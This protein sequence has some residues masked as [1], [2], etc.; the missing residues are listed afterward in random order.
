M[1][2]SCPTPDPCGIHGLE[3]NPVL[4]TGRWPVSVAFDVTCSGNGSTARKRT[5]GR[6]GTAL[7]AG[8][9]EPVSPPSLSQRKQDHDK[10]EDTPKDYPAQVRRQCAGCGS[11]DHHRPKPPP[12]TPPS[13]AGERIL[14]GNSAGPQRGIFRPAFRRPHSWHPDGERGT[15]RVSLGCSITGAVAKR[16]LAGGIPG[17]EANHCASTPRRCSSKAPGAGFQGG[18]PRSLGFSEGRPGGRAHRQAWDQGLRR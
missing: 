2:L 6:K 5:V 11:G 13:R 3:P 1:L 12:L 18:S 7:S 9:A 15:N 16:L 8:L 17:R 14:T 10:R 4:D